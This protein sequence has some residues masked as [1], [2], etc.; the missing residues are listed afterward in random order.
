MSIDDFW[1]DIDADE[2]GVSALDDVELVEH[3]N[4]PHIACVLLVDTSSSMVVDNRIGKL[5]SGLQ[6]F[7]QAVQNDPVARRRVDISVVSFASGVQVESN[8]CSIDAWTPPTLRAN[9]ATSMGKGLEEALRLTK[10]RIKTYLQNGTDAYVPWVFLITDG[11]PTDM[12]VGDSR[13]EHVKQMLADGEAR[14]LLSFFAVAVDDSAVT[15]L[16]QLSA[17]RLPLV[18]NKNRWDEMFLWLSSSFSGISRSRPGDAL[19]LSDP[20]NTAAGGWGSV[21]A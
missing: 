12:Q 17:T 13:W 8:F 7:K 5:N 6:L 20:T 4:E 1:D 19:P 10:E 14:A 2:T 11:H 21:R 16:K 15:P 3:G 18:L 9:G